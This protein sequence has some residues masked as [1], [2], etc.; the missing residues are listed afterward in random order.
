MPVESKQESEAVVAGEG[1]GAGVTAISGILNLNDHAFHFRHLKYPRYDREIPP[2]LFEYPWGT[3]APIN[4]GPDPAG[5]IHFGGLGTMWQDSTSPGLVRYKAGG[6]PGNESDGQIVYARDGA[7]QGVEQYLI[8]GVRGDKVVKLR[9]SVAFRDLFP[10][11]A[12]R[13][14][15]ALNVLKPRDY[16][17]I[18]ETPGAVHSFVNCLKEAD[19]DGYMKDIRQADLDAISSISYED[20]QAQLKNLPENERREVESG[21]TNQKTIE[22]IKKILMGLRIAVGLIAGIAAVLAA[23][24]YVAIHF[25]PVGWAV[26]MGKAKVLALVAA[27]GG[28]L[29]TF[30]LL[31][32]FVLS[33]FEGKSGAAALFEDAPAQ[34]QG[35]A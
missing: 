11:I 2:G 9:S 13:F 30:I 28:L 25:G 19:K 23:G 6:S 14:L 29:V 1:R 3:T 18:A 8:L 35:T 22:V 5:L 16:R 10:D 7:W 12:E 24:I 34:V 20:L 15:T 21:K 32:E 26:A 17:A 33:F 4:W 27:A 31:V